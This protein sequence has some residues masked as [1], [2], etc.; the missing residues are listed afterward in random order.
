M[1]QYNKHIVYKYILWHCLWV[2]WLGFSRFRL[3]K[4]M[5][6]YHVIYL[7]TDWPLSMSL[8]N[9]GPVDVIENIDPVSITCS[10]D[11]NPECGYVWTD[12]SGVD[13]ASDELFY[14]DKLT[15]QQAGDYRCT[16]S[17]IY[18][19]KVKSVQVNVL[20]RLSNVLYSLIFV[21]NN[22]ILHIQITSICLIITLVRC[23]QYYILAVL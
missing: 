22:P 9:P 12:A 1:L 3:L 19:S 2:V 11:C 4:H 21:Y 6:V 17:N 5:H 18:G 8:N 16:A 7:L 23:L 13:V 10:A 15:R 14:L 20:C